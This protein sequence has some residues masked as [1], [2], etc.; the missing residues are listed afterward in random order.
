[1]ASPQDREPGAEELAIQYEESR[2]LGAEL[3]RLTKQ[4]AESSLEEKEQL[5][6]LISTAAQRLALTRSSILRAGGSLDQEEPRAS[7][8]QP[9]QGQEQS[10]GGSRGQG[11]AGAQGQGTAGVQGQGGAG[12]QGG[13][14]TGSR[15]P[16]QRRPTE[17]WPLGGGP[18]HE[19]EEEEDDDGQGGGQFY[20]EMRGGRPRRMKGLS[21]VPKP[22]ILLDGTGRGS[23]PGF[24]LWQQRVRVYSAANGWNSTLGPGFADLEEQQVYLWSGF[25]GGYVAQWIAARQSSWA[26]LESFLRELQARWVPR[27]QQALARDLLANL[28]F[29]RSTGLHAHDAQFQELVGNAAGCSEEETLHLYLSSFRDDPV[30]LGKIRDRRPRHWTDASLT[31]AEEL[32]WMKQ[33]EEQRAAN[34]PRRQFGGPAGLHQ[35]DAGDGASFERSVLLVLQRYDQERQRRQGQAGR[36]GPGQA[37]GGQQQRRPTPQSVGI[38]QEEMN[39]RWKQGVC[40]KC[41]KEGH[42]WF[43]CR[44]QEGTN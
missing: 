36:G 2:E 15:G 29:R 39:E 34:R 22:P 4:L 35:M 20:S 38:S 33:E 25:T 18:A 13:H 40:L 8:Q 23:D 26:S 11:S 19:W 10:P 30:L 9:G 32:A 16:E 21:N 12:A 41:G 14:G 24:Q 43:H 42:R 28:R 3:E 1:M 44:T 37:R 6:A 7:Q 17:R 31:A 27:E 5:C